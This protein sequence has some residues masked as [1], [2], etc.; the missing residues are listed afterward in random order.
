M[1]D[2]SVN[3]F[4]TIANNEFSFLK[5][6]YYHKNKTLFTF[7][8]QVSIFQSNEKDRLYGLSFLFGLS[9]GT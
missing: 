6:I 8:I 2:F 7:R 5:S 9:D 4:F 3:L 1:Q